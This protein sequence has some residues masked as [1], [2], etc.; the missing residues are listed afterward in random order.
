PLVGA[1]ARR[2]TGTSSTLSQNELASK[3]SPP[4]LVPSARQTGR[5]MVLEIHCTWPSQKAAVTPPPGGRLRAERSLGNDRRW[6]VVDGALMVVRGMFQ[7]AATW[8][9]RRVMTS[10]AL[11]LGRLKVVK[12]LAFPHQMKPRRSGAA[13]PPWPWITSDAMSVLEVPSLIVGKLAC[14]WP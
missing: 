4:W 2:G 14:G 7:G 3:T 9:A 6:A 12:P 11:E 10:G 5:L 8:Q 13:S 1:A